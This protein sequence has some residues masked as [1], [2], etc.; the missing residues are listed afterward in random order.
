MGGK[1]ADAKMIHRDPYNF[2]ESAVVTTLKAGN[3]NGFLPPTERGEALAKL[4][5]PKIR[6]D[7]QGQPDYFDYEVPAVGVYCPGKE[8]DDTRIVHTSILPINIVLDIVNF[9]SHIS[10]Q[11]TTD[12]DDKVKQIAGHIEQYLRDIRQDPDRDVSGGILSIGSIVEI[13]ASIFEPAYMGNSG[14]I[15]E[16]GS[17]FQVT[18]RTKG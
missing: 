16:G 1:G 9:S 15:F 5:H 7:E 12:A 10:I 4:I 13:G 2:L 18:I 8:Q 14:W 11:D 6:R 3:Q 17:S